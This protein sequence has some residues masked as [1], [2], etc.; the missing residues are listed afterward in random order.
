MNETY[1]NVY[2]TWMYLVFMYVLPFGGLSVLNSLMYLDVRRS[3]A[4]Q[5]WQLPQS[6]SVG[7]KKIIWANQLPLEDISVFCSFQQLPQ[8]LERL[9]E[10]TQHPSR[11]LNLAL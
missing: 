6:F 7:C 3:N 9:F 1:L 8:T 11:A 4:R 5:V 2:I 10:L